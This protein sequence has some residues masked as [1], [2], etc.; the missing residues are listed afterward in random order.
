MKKGSL[1]PIGLFLA[2]PGSMYAQVRIHIPA[3]H[4]TTHQTIRA[5]VENNGRSPVTFCAEFGPDSMKATGS[6]SLPI[7]FWAQ[8]YSAGKWS[9]LL[10]GPDVGGLRGT[11]V[12]DSGESKEFPFRLNE[13]GRMRLQLEYWSGSVETLD[14]RNPPKSSKRVT[15][16]TIVMK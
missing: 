14:C 9:T 16:K 12:L 6:E 3:Q 7:P 4:H 15:S 5:R 2:L 1:I 10:T 13:T 8:K 11:I